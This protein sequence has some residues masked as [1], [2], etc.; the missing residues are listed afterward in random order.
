MAYRWKPG[1]SSHANL[2]RLARNQLRGAIDELTSPE[3][4]P[5]E[6]V[7]QARLHLKKLRALVRL[8]RAEAGTVFAEE[9]ARYRDFSHELSCERD[10]QATIDAFE[11]LAEHAERAWQADAGSMAALGAARQWLIDQRPHSSDANG[12]FSGDLAD[13]LRTALDDAQRWT[14]RARD[15]KTIWA[16]LEQ[17]YRSGRRA[18][19]R[20]IAEPSP[21]A[22][23]EWRKQ[24]KY[25]R[26]HV[27]LFQ[28]AWPAV[29]TAHYDELKRLSDLLGDDHDLV[30]L[31]QTLAEAE[32]SLSRRALDDISELIERR[33]DELHS[34]A[35]PL[36]QMLYGEKPKQLA[37]RLRGYWRVYAG[38]LEFRG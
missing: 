32:D 22:L 1:A 18:L 5:A 3:K 31:R 28:V 21:E 35:L 11:H 16:G 6:A 8:V 27:R 17:S 36:G 9:N 37:R 29:L 15:D 4:Q 2:R 30:V 24:V 14:N 7:H 12:H 26:Y 25:H 19:R 10:A 13:R 34:H 33:R 23:H 38:S 20:A